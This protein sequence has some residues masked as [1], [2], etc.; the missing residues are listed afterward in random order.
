MT[1]ELASNEWARVTSGDWKDNDLDICYK[2][3]YIVGHFILSYGFM[4]QYMDVVHDIPSSICSIQNLTTAEEII[5]YMEHYAIIDNNVL[6]N[7]RRMVKNPKEGFI[8]LRKGN[9]IMCIYKD[10]NNESK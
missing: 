9:V 5:M 3:R 4:L 10:N 2:G 7:M 1:Q 6:L 8:V